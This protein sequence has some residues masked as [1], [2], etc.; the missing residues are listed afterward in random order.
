MLVFVMLIICVLP[1]LTDAMIVTK[2]GSKYD[3]M[4]AA[5]GKAFAAHVEI[6][7]RLQIISDDLHL[8][9]GRHDN[10]NDDEYALFSE[11][12]D[13]DVRIRERK[14]AVVWSSSSKIIP[15]SDGSPVALLA[16]R[17]ECS[18]ESK[19]RVASELFPIVQYLIVYDQHPPQ[20]DNAGH[21]VTEPPL[22]VMKSYDPSFLNHKLGLLYIS[23][24][25]GSSLL[26]HIRSSTDQ[27]KADG[28]CLV[29]LNGEVPW[30]PN[31]P[32][33]WVMGLFMMLSM[34]ATVWLC[35]NTGY[36]RSDGS[37]IIIGNAHRG[38]GGP[39]S[40]R[41]NQIPLL[42]MEEV[43][44]LPELE[45]H[46]SGISTN[47][48]SNNGDEECPLINTP[49]KSG[50]AGHFDMTSCS[51]CLE[52][53]QQG[54]KIRCLPCNHVFH[55]DCIVPWLTKN[56]STC[57]LC[58]EDLL[59]HYGCQP[60]DDDHTRMEEEHSDNGDG[61][62]VRIDTRSNGNNT[63]LSRLFPWRI[64]TATPN[65]DSDSDSHGHSEGEEGSVA[66]S[67]SLLEETEEQ[68]HHHSRVT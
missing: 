64:P 30:Q 29:E 40:D 53:F 42:T 52:D 47:T 51:I 45:F 10:A 3:S 14:E 60:C 61:N 6:K 4:P 9:G 18:Y 54:D 21:R 59:D 55:S 15:P 36:I 16:K 38:T 37:V 2:S 11:L 17:G 50:D 56:Q 5:F 20:R 19:A 7:A 68:N 27:T 67:Y 33:G 65:A 26:H 49:N 35:C 57:P 32:D 46:T 58:K 43:T 13:D 8:C 34:F 63:F 12:N 31:Q 41:H 66:M 48:D 1:K 39:N 62:Y 44:E 24:L 28:G 23:N 22:I 25:A